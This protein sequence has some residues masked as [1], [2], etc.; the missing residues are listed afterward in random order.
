[1]RPFTA[2]TVLVLW[3]FMPLL[4][5]F[6]QAIHWP[7]ALQWPLRLLLGACM[8]GASILLA[9]WLI[10]QWGILPRV[11]RWKPELEQWA[12]RSLGVKVQVA[13]IDVGG[14]M[15]SPMLTLRDLRLLDPQGRTALQLD[16]VR[17]VLA[18]RSLLPRSLVDWAPHFEQ[19]LIEAPRLE[20]RRDPQGQLWIAG[21]AL[22]RQGTQRGSS[23]AAD[24]LFR[25][26]E[27]VVL[28]GDVSW[29]DQQRGAPALHLQAV[30]LV[31]R[32]R[33]TRHQVRVD[34]VPPPGWGDAFTLRGDFRSS[35]L[36]VA[37]LQGAGDWR[38]WRGQVQADLPLI[39]VEQLSTY[40]SLPWTVRQGRASVAAWLDVAQGTVTRSSAD[41][42]LRDVLVQAGASASPLDLLWLRGRVAYERT[43]RK[44]GASI[45]LDLQQLQFE[46]AAGVKW[47]TSDIHLTSEHDARGQIRSGS[48][49][50]AGI[51]L[52]RLAELADHLPLPPRWHAQLDSLQAKGRIERLR[53]RWQGTPEQ[54]Q[55]YWAAG[56]VKGLGL[57]AQA[58]DSTGIPT[59]SALT[60]SHAPHPAAGRPGLRNADLDFEF[61]EREG[62]LSAAMRH[63]ELAFPGV[64]EEPAIPVDEL[65]AALTWRRTERP[66]RPAAWS[67]QVQSLKLANADLQGTAQARWQ[68]GLGTSH[69]GHL[70]GHL[71]LKARLSRANVARV[72]RYLPLAIGSE[73]RHYLRES[74]L[75]GHVSNLTAVVR[76]DLRQ[77]PFE[78]EGSGEFRLHAQVE[79]AR[80]AYVPKTDTHPAWPPFTDLR[81]EVLIDGQRLS[82]QRGSARLGTSGDG[83]YAINQVHGQISDILHE[84]V[85]AIEGQGN[86]PL[87]DALRYVNEAPIGAW[88][89]HAL[90]PTRASGDASLKLALNIPLTK[91]E[92]TAVRG[93]VQLTGN[94]VAMR[95]DVPVLAGARARVDFTEGGFSVSNASARTVGGTLNFEGAQHPDGSVRFIGAGIATADGLRRTPEMPWL[96]ALARPM[97]GQAAY[98]LQLGFVRGQPEIVVT[99]PLT[100]MALKLPAPLGKGDTETLP[101]RVSVQPHGDLGGMASDLLRVEVGKLLDAQYLRRHAS[102]DGTGAPQVVRGAIGLGQA[103]EWPTQGVAAQVAWPTV[104]VD[105]W[106]EWSRRASA[107]V[108]PPHKGAADSDASGAYHPSRLQIRTA[109]LQVMNRQLSQ[110][111]ASIR[112]EANGPAPRNNAWLIDIDADQLAGKLELQGPGFGGGASSHQDD[113]VVARFSRLSIPRS[114]VSALGDQLEQSEDE[115]PALDIAVDRFELH[116]NLLGR[117]ELQASNLAVPRMGESRLWRIGKLTVAGPDAQLQAS[118]QWLRRGGVLPSQTTMDFKLDIHDA[119]L[120]LTRFGM[121]K[122]VR[123][124]AGSLSGEVRWRGAPTAFDWATLGGNMHLSVARGQFLR[125]DAGAAK[126]LGILSLQSLPRRFLLDFRDLTQAGFPF[127]RV[128]GDF[129]IERG[130]ASTRNLQVHGVQALIAVEGQADLVN[131]T[132]DLQVWVVPEI[133]AGAASL[134]YAVVNPAVGLGTLLGQIF[135]RRPLAE[136]ATRQFHVTG[137]WDAPV[138]NQIERMPRS[139]LPG[140]VPAPAA[141]QAGST[142]RDPATTP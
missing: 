14:G 16:Q 28:K 118:G 111:R 17:A 66:N 38:H 45:K 19:I 129:G 82:L 29:L 126:L 68:T 31:L 59:S 35:L 64:F 117:L 67:V 132:Q 8:V 116:G 102:A 65:K 89:G 112:R 37:G 1:M 40:V 120:L 86:G 50:T 54:A 7:R 57:A 101:L 2:S 115:L 81:T 77:F 23:A 122:A 15:W 12:S 90:A 97:S 108:S 36:T 119:G 78:R 21:I 26:R 125:A 121:D 74:L 62:R 100:G 127:D 39:D 51:D 134:A 96:A 104:S 106:L 131:E 85:L 142:A 92:A 47:P 60:A 72:H 71:D 63:G 27:V 107:D 124:G 83:R 87:N 49:D 139:A 84:P 136:A 22:Q 103:P 105:D 91:T 123:S 48:L 98:R 130:V 13:A 75:A 32:N 10:L 70:P 109:R 94:D 9:A 30:Q 114:E 41:L 20:L 3:S 69:A 55:H 95:P 53:L 52:T 44:Q 46:T 4:T 79:Q 99:S 33:I 93:S 133:N 25:Q 34:A 140:V 128:E 76:G 73:T 138:V 135:L 43:A 88:I 113:R 24:W 6:P 80:Y 42:A 137:V 58:A 110:V 18:P 56:Q 61:T 5:I 141:A 11:E